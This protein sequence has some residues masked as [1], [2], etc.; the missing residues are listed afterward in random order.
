MLLTQNPPLLSPSWPALDQDMWLAKKPRALAQSS[1][2]IDSGNVTGSGT[3]KHAHFWSDIGNVA[4]VDT[5]FLY[6]CTKTQTMNS[7]KD[8]NNNFHI[9]LRLLNECMQF[10]LFCSFP[11]AEALFSST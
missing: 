9:A 1:T 11:L 2:G 5:L 8:H 4:I 3:H 6:Q 7:T 10:G